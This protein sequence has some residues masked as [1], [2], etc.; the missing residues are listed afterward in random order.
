MKGKTHRFY[1]GWVIVAVSF[2]T[3]FL[4]VGIRFSFGVFYVAILGEY[5]WSRAETAGAFSIAMVIHALFAPVTGILI[6]RFGP[7]K[8]FPL[9]ATLLVMGLVAASRTTGIWHLYLFFGVV[10]AIGINTLSY[11][12]HMSLIPKWFIRRRGF[13]SGLVLAGIGVGT[14]VLAPFIQFINDTLGWRFAFLILAGIILGVVVP[15]TVL[16]QRRSPEEVSQYPDGIVPGSNGTLA[17]RQEGFHEDT[18]SSALSGQWTLRAALCTRPLWWMVLMNFCAGFQTHMLVVHQAAHI[19]DAGYSRI[20]AASLVGLV[21]L[22]ASAGG[23][24]CGFLSDRVGREIAYTLGGS[25]AFMGVL[26]FLFVWDTTSPWILS[27][28]VIFYG[29]GLGSTWPV[30]AAAIGDLFPGDSLG[31]ILGIMTIG[32]GLGGALGTYIGGYLYDIVGSY[33]FPFLLVLVS[34]ILGILGIWMASPGHRRP[35]AKAVEG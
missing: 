7:R 9:G 10:V 21:S 34:I 14:M 27:G 30:G 3:I 11:T 23:I 31:R 35:F 33:T 26:F 25:A 19:V 28:F 32:F 20:L 8:L 1:Y 24:L 6:D 16:F 22:L 5:G 13:A 12:P 15:M 18:R 2:V 4:A 29:L 17:P